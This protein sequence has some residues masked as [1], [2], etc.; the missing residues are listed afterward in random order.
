MLTEE[1][2]I[3]GQLLHLFQAM[4]NYFKEIL[5]GYQEILHAVDSKQYCPKN[6]GV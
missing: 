3:Q 2:L 5:D 1:S 4:A 6:T